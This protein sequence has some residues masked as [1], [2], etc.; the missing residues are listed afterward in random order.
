MRGYCQRCFDGHSPVSVAVCGWPALPVPLPHGGQAPQTLRAPG[1]A[2]E[3]PGP[4]HVSAYV[5]ASLSGG[6]KG[7]PAKTLRVQ[8]AL[9]SSCQR[10][11]AVS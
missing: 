2:S 4:R 10:V 9:H 7:R 3:G 6:T 8:W 1:S 5:S 11:L